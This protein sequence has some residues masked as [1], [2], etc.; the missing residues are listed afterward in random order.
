M[1]VGILVGSLSSKSVSFGI[2][3]LILNCGILEADLVDINLPFY[4]PDIEDERIEPAFS[5]FEAFRSQLRDHDRFIFISPEYN[6]SL[7]AILKNAIDIASRPVLSD[8]IFGKKALIIG[9]GGGASGGALVRSHLRHII[10]NPYLNLRVMQTHEVPIPF[11]HEKFK[12]GEL[13]PVIL[14]V[15]L[16]ALEVF[17]DF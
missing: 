14:D 2:A 12:D 6:Y 11:S 10:T 4:N 9:V 17:K 16:K 3:N 1:S 5:R 8:H 7:S 13:D 15:L